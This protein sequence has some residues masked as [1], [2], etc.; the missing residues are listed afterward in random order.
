MNQ[1]PPPAMGVI[2]LS[3]DESY[4]MLKIKV[5]YMNLDV[6]KNVI[7]IRVEYNLASSETAKSRVTSLLVAIERYQK[8]EQFCV[9]S[10]S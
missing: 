8:G 3:R 4:S 6:I 1:T 7:E 9:S 5:P 10:V 2:N